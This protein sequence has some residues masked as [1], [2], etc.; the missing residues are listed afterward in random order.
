M[1]SICIPDG[2]QPVVDNR[3]A[4]VDRTG[5]RQS[6]MKYKAP[7]ACRD[8]SARG[9]VPLIAAVLALGT[10]AA[11]SIGVASADDGSKT[12]TWGDQRAGDC[13]LFQGAKW[14]VHYDGTAHF[15]G[16]VTSGSD[17]DAWLMWANLKD[18]SGAILGP[19]YKWSG[20]DEK[21]V[22]NLPDKSQRYRWTADG[23]FDI[24]LYPLIAGMRL[25]NHC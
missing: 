5:V 8:R 3:A 12:Y 1:T 20:H 22:Q 15:E 19:I 7:S 2:T 4:A 25:D 9:P 16:L 10:V 18:S 17:N 23:M 13:T 14:T 6:P 21:F 11:T 24:D